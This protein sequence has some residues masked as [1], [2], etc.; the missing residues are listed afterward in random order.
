ML[1]SVGITLL[2]KLGAALEPVAIRLEDESHRHAG[3]AGARPDGES[4]FTLT[5]SAPAF[6]G[7]SLVERHR[8]VNAAVAAELKER[9]HALAIRVQGADAV[10]GEIDADDSRLVG[11]LQSCGLGTDDL[12]NAKLIG[13]ARGDDLI[14]CGGIELHGDAALLRSIAVAPDAR[15]RGHGQAIVLRLLAQAGAREAWVLTEGAE[16]FFAGLGFK[17]RERG[18]APKEIQASGQFAG[19]RCGAATAMRRPAVGPRV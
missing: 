17:A 13:L 4:H 18:G 8:M 1:G 6:Q 19:K 7:K 3:H 12:G 10:F 2:E 9:V 14:A 11:L 15:G 5:I 16:E